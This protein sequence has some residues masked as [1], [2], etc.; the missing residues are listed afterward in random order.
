MQYSESVK[1]TKLY[2]YGSDDSNQ[3]RCDGK[4]RLPVSYSLNLQDFMT[5][6]GGR[7]AIGRQFDLINSFFTVDASQ[8]P[9]GSY[10]KSEIAKLLGYSRY[11]WVMNEYDFQDDNDDYFERIYIFNTISFQIV[12]DALFVVNSSGERQ[13]QNFAVIPRTDLK[14]PENFDFVGGNAFTTLLNIVLERSI[15]PNK[16][17]KKV[18]IEFVGDVQRSL[19][20]G[21]SY[22]ADLLK[23]T[24]WGGISLD[25]M[26]DDYKAALAFFYSY[27]VIGPLPVFQCLIN[28]IT[29]GDP[30]LVTFKGI[31]YN[32]QVPGEFLLVGSSKNDFQIQVRQELLKNSKAISINTAVATRFNQTNIGLYTTPVIPGNLQGTPQDDILTCAVDTLTVFGSED[33][34]IAEYQTASDIVFLESNAAYRNTFGYYL[35]DQSG[36]PVSGK[37]IWADARS[38]VR[39]TAVNYD[40]NVSKVNLGFF[41]IADGASHNAGLSNGDVLT[42]SQINGQWTPIKNSVALR[43]AYSNAPAFYS[44]VNLNS[45]HVQHQLFRDNTQY[46]EDEY[47]GGDRNYLNLIFQTTIQSTLTIT[48]GDLLI[49]SSGIENF[50]Y[51]IDVDGV[52]TI[53]NFDP[54]Q[55]RITFYSNKNKNISFIDVDQGVFIK[56]NENAASLKGILLENLKS[57]NV[58]DRIN[59][60]HSTRIQRGHLF[61]NG[62][63]NELSSGQL[64]FVDG[65]I[66]FRNGRQYML[67]SP[68]GDGFY[69]TLYSDR[70][71]V[72]VFLYGGREL[73]SIFGLLG[74]N[75]HDSDLSLQLRDGTSLG[76]EIPDDIFYS[77]YA[78]S[79]RIKENKSLFLYFNNQ[80]FSTFQKTLF[81]KKQITYR[82]F[83]SDEINRAKVLA[84]NAG[85]DESQFYYE[86]ILL[87]I[88]A[89]GANITELEPFY[90]PNKTVFGVL[91]LSNDTYCLNKHEGY[92]TYKCKAN[93]TSNSVMFLI[94][95]CASAGAVVCLCISALICFLSKRQRS[96]VA[97]EN[98]QPDTRNNNSHLSRNSNAYFGSRYELVNK[99]SEIE[100]QI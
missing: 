46:W 20:D 18:N 22:F 85:Y 74:P 51:V 7:F 2:L 50:G 33:E 88:L 17:G 72:Q 73:N 41:I 94:V 62:T 53:R 31:A 63:A 12:D 76:L 28:A 91:T 9:E 58:S 23:K 32:F 67:I 56:T 15:D 55:D 95:I 24:T 11:D 35:A 86:D 10:T 8:L 54:S 45:D 80:N 38:V 57:V 66:V 26:Y 48:G 1:I 42:F 16:I 78:E 83:S 59:F 84:S 92:L 44:N 36:H 64:I 49:A 75:N 93:N 39:G 69:A 81:L 25:K 4:T 61:I 19:Y 97:S 65:G 68:S 27:S 3:Y 87:E 71:D 6:G 37:I 82:D 99:G 89:G 13:V 21:G 47:G 34:G 77:L 40:F 5:N 30:H 90:N 60:D 43:S 96:E 98:I 79:W 14:I 52:D 29:W 100:L 70:I